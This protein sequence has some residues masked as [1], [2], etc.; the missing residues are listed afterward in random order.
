MPSRAVLTDIARALDLEFPDKEAL[1]EVA[2]FWLEPD[3]VVSS[4]ARALRDPLLSAQTR[5]LIKGQVAGLLVYA[6]HEVA[7]AKRREILGTSN[8]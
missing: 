5:E 3:P 1:F 4:L 6:N 2:G 7:A 8:M